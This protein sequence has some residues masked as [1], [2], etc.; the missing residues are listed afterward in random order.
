MTMLSS[1][2]DKVLRHVPNK[3]SQPS[4]TDAQCIP[5][6]SLNHDTMDNRVFDGGS[7]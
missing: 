3:C 4:L 7:G 5:N 2:S 6:M 1:L